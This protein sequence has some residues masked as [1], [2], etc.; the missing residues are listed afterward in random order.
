[1]MSDLINDLL[2]QHVINKYIFF[3]LLN[4]LFFCCAYFLLKILQQLCYL[5]VN[6]YFAK[7]H[8]QVLK[9]IE[10]KHLISR[11]CWFVILFIVAE[12]DDILYVPSL[13]FTRKYISIIDHILHLFMIA[14]VAITICEILNILSDYRYVV[15]S[16]PVEETADKEEIEEQKRK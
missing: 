7:R 12:L 3:L 8:P 2:S 5:I 14:V 10:D 9:S 11:G 1:M 15:K 13:G 16:Q 4:C 6:F